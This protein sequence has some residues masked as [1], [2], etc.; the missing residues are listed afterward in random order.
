MCDEKFY[1]LITK[2]RFKQKSQFQ[3]SRTPIFKLFS[4]YTIILHSSQC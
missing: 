1:R 3:K 2:T 4:F